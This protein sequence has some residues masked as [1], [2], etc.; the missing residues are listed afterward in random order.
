ML[1]RYHWGLGVGH[2]YSH[3]R[4][5]SHSCP[6]FDDLEHELSVSELNV[7]E[8]WFL[9]MCEAESRVG[10]NCIAEGDPTSTDSSISL[11]HGFGNLDAS[12]SLADL[13]ALEWEISEDDRGDINT[14][15]DDGSDPDPNAFEM[16]EMYSSA[17][18]NGDVDE[19]D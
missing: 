3:V 11:T 16:C 19:S 14:E 1:M 8:W 6:Y 12:L 2:T 15:S 18:A 4:D 10:D 7:L 9:G 13:E 5:T 17:C